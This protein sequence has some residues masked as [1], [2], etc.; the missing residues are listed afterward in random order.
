[1]AQL[2]KTADAGNGTEE[3][4]GS[5]ETVCY[6]FDVPDTVIRKVI[7]ENGCTEVEEVT[8]ICDAGGGCTSCHPDIEELIDE[9]N[10]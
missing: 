6:C 5:G 8:E 4:K 7:S 3:L 10:G 2:D 1:L 9:I